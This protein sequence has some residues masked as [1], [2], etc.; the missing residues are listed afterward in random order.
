MQAMSK[1]NYEMTLD[2]TRTSELVK[3]INSNLQKMIYR[4]KKINNET[5]LKKDKIVNKNE[6]FLEEN[7]EPA[8]RI[9]EEATEAITNVKKLSS[10]KNAAKYTMCHKQLNKLK[11]KKKRK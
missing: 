4:H 7:F 3:S 9:E 6:E 5:E 8:S 10:Q 1:S 2:I 11:P